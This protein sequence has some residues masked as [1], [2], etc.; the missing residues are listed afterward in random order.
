MVGHDR[1]PSQ[2]ANVG[3]SGNSLS[4]SVP[5]Q[6]VTLFVIPV[7]AAAPAFT[8]TATATPSSVSRGATTTI[9]PVVTDTGGALSNGVVDVEVYNAAGTKVGQ[10]FWQAQSFTSR[11]KRSY[12]WN[13]VTPNTPGTYTVKVGIFGANW[14]PLYFWNNVATITVK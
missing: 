12:S 10:Q 1:L 4:T 8:V 3:V 13:W 9:K 14:S 6:S 2:V 11:Q 5:A 7:V